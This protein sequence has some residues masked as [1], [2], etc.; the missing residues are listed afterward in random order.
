M[1]AKAAKPRP[2]RIR[3][4]TDEEAR[5]L[6]DRAARRALNM[7]GEDFLR[8]WDAGEFDPIIDDPKYH[9]KIIGVA[10]LLP[11]VKHIRVGD[12]W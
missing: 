8:K 7:S 5:E 4:F 3:P 2:K 6:F 11:L 9:N 1:R 10:M 12:A